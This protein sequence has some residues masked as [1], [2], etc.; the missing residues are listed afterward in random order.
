M[1]ANSRYYKVFHS[2]LDKKT[3]GNLA[4][5]STNSRK[6]V[7]LGSIIGS[8]VLLGIFSIYTALLAFTG[9]S[10][11]GQASESAAVITS[12]IKLL[13]TTSSYKIGDT[14]QVS[15]TLTNT[16]FSE[17]VQ[18]V[19]LTVKNTLDQ[20]TFD[21]AKLVNSGA[22]A[23]D[24]EIQN[25]KR[26]FV[27]SISPL[28][29]VEV[30]ASGKL[31]N[32]QVGYLAFA[33]EVEYSN[34][35]GTTTDK[36]NQVFASI[37]GSGAVNSNFLTLSSDVSDI[38]FGESVNVKLSTKE[39]AIQKLAKGKIFVTNKKGVEVQVIECSIQTG[40]VCENELKDLP[41]GTF[42]VLFY[43]DDETVYSNILTLS[44]KNSKPLFNPSVKAKL[45][46]PY[47]DNSI[48]GNV[49]VLAE[50]VLD[51]ETSTSFEC[52]FEVVASGSETVVYEFTAAVKTD[53]TCTGEFTFSN[54][55]NAGSY[56]VRIKGTG[57]KQTVFMKELSSVNTVPLV[58][59]YTAKNGIQLESK[60][61]KKLSDTTQNINSLAMVKVVK[62]NLTVTTFKAV[63]GLALSYSQGVFNTVLPLEV[64][65]QEGV[66]KLSISTT[67]TT[68]TG[69]VVRESVLTSL[70]IGGVS[71]PISGNLVTVTD[72]SLVAGKAFTLLLSDVKDRLGN[73]SSS[74]VCS[75]SFY[76][77]GSEKALEVAGEVKEGKCSVLVK[78]EQLLRSGK[79][80]VVFKNKDNDVLQSDYITV[81]PA[82]AVSF[83]ELV[84]DEELPLRSTSHKAYV[85]PIVD[86][87]G[88][89]V[90]S[91]EFF[92]QVKDS[93]TQTIYT[94]QTLTV[95]RGFATTVLPASLFDTPNMTLSVLDSESKVL[96]TKDYVISE[97]VKEVTFELASSV[98]SNESITASVKSVQQGV[99]ECKL[100]VFYANELYE[101]RAVVN[102]EKKECV[103]S[104][105]P[106]N[107]FI[108]ERYLVA[109][110][111][112]GVV[113][114]SLISVKAAEARSNFLVFP[115]VA[116]F[117]NQQSQVQL[118]TTPIIDLHGILVD[119]MVSK[120]ELNGLKKDVVI[121]K[122]FSYI[123][124]VDGDIKKSNTIDSISGKSISIDLDWRASSFSKA[125]SSAFVWLGKSEINY[126][127]DTIKLIKGSNSVKEKEAVV[128][129]FSVESNT[130]NF[131]QQGQ[132][133][134]KS[135]LE[136]IKIADT[137][138]VVT[139]PSQSNYVINFV[140]EGR[141]VASFEQLVTEKVISL[142]PCT[143]SP[144]QLTVV[145]ELKRD[146]T[147]KVVDEKGV[148]V[149]TKEFKYN[150][151]LVV[152]VE[153]VNAFKTYL[154]ELMVSGGEKSV[155]STTGEV[156]K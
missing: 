75:A 36:T 8:Y 79:T 124:L 90:I 137:C 96:L 152:S 98:V 127:A 154:V 65:D 143:T 41:I 71:S 49:V 17:A 37:N 33:G 80:L 125:V 22:K 123:Q 141:V 89:E 82:I 31:T 58:A 38:T 11:K 43:S 130:C 46:L 60:T 29:K 5:W 13:D 144:C 113:K 61:V 135:V 35:D 155:F 2:K 1:T 32:Q 14:V 45:S 99:D 47:G 42:N 142:T 44:V 136:S 56:D 109:F 70:S 88:N 73:D 129:K 6:K 104:V 147:V 21:S 7:I 120:L 106:E 116:R 64:V 146:S 110:T 112:D 78:D 25:G 48:A 20:A 28:N 87:Y 74:S 62:P 114:H 128:L 57:L 52:K 102:L 15:V 68:A 101:E 76:S 153:G 59:S 12:S 107:G 30:I 115:S 138:L 26:V 117:S 118:L 19:S 40:V 111:L 93:D 121:D 133:G 51:F 66:Y 72:G 126:V 4:R 18:N 3:V 132:D 105:K 39:G 94:T 24:L 145:D 108:K 23:L 149:Y 140:K 103:V 122:G 131:I 95:E 67:D 53:N 55:K 77:I 50:Q 34:F 150:D 54:V 97:T 69:E 83:G 139:K 134:S 81:L 148:Q 16:S 100:K 156:L 9:D 84:L 10:R 85:G 86:G 151:P 119:N 27:G 91:G 63:D 92:V